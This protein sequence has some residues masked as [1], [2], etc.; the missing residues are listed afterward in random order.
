MIDRRTALAGVVGMFGAQ[1]FAP[2]ARAAGLAPSETV[3]VIS[4]GPA[5]VQIF[6][7]AQ[8]ALMAVLSERVIPTTDTPGALAAGVP[9]YIEKLLADWAEPEDRI[10]ILSGLDAIEMRSLT[11]YKLSAA[12]ADAAQQ[13]ALLTLA[14]E[15]KIPGGKAF[16]EAFRQL[17][18]TGYYTSEIGMTQEREYLPVP[19]EYNGEFLYSQINKVY[20]A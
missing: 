19:G 4:Q 14:M 20:S 1:L 8:R 7:P 10:P 3:P 16:F 17:V 5:S 6:A 12:I 2:I 15:D 13:D 11:D 18:I 9:D